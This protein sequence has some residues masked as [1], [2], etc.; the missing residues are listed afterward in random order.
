ME[1]NINFILIPETEL[2]TR[3]QTITQEKIKKLKE[4]LATLRSQIATTHTVEIFDIGDTIRM[5]ENYLKYDVENDE[6]ILE[7]NFEKYRTNVSEN[8]LPGKLVEEN[9]KVLDKFYSHISRSE[10][11]NKRNIFSYYSSISDEEFVHERYVR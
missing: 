5:L 2:L 3:N 6:K 1:I 11:L 7:M 8:E 10:L 9:K 4:E